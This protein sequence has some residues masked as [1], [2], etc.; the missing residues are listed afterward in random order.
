MNE[1]S[2]NEKIVCKKDVIINGQ[3]KFKKNKKY[4]VLK[5]FYINP[6]NTLID[7][8]PPGSYLHY[9]IAN[10]NGIEE[11]FTGGEADLYFSTIV[12]MRK[13]KIEKI[14]KQE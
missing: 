4:I 2:I 6:E 8:P 1:F 13:N 10:E 3:P 12:D 9:F 7:E 11:Y 5:A 14:N